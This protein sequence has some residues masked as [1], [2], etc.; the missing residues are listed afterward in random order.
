MV[1]SPESVPGQFAYG[2]MIY[3]I[4]SEERKYI[5][6][7]ADSRFDLKGQQV[8]KRL[9]G[10]KASEWKT[11]WYDAYTAGVPQ[12]AQFLSPATP[13]PMTFRAKAN[14]EQKQTLLTKQEVDSYPEFEDGEVMKSE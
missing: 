14:E 2:L 5:K 8:L 4:S 3:R 10:L 12:E 6:P 7:R 1:P 13:T 11:I 9:I